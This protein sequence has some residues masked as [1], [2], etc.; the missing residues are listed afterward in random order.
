MKTFS[1]KTFLLLV[2]TISV[3][4]ANYVFDQQVT[5][6]KSQLR[7]LH[8]VSNSLIVDDPEKIA[9]VRMDVSTVLRDFQWKAYLPPVNN[10]E[11]F[12][13]CLAQDSNCPSKLPSIDSELVEKI[14]IPSGTHDISFTEVALTKKEKSKIAAERRD[15]IQKMFEQNKFNPENLPKSGAG[16]FKSGGRIRSGTTRPAPFYELKVNG[17]GVGQFQH[18]LRKYA[19]WDLLFDSSSVQQPADQPFVLS[20]TSWKPKYELYLW[21]QK[22]KK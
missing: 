20:P 19:D 8:V 15:A 13:L 17:E 21:I 3:W 10:D 6:S 18:Q 7:R 16:D 9:V 11:T 4:I 22:I 2:A 1:L 14:P 12:V 5:E